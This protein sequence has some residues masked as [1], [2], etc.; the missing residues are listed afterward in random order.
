MHLISKVLFR[1]DLLM[2]SSS[3]LCLQTPVGLEM[4]SASLQALNILR[5]DR[6]D[7]DGVAHIKKG[8]TIFKVDYV[9][10]YAL[11]LEE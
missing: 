9:K 10:P 4:V 5:K 3:A 8:T 1:T 7:F 2:W 6:V 11:E